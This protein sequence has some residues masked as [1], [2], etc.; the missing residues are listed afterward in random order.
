[1]ADFLLVH[2]SCHGA[3]CWRHVVPALQA[4]GHSVR[5]IDLPGHGEDRTPAADVTADLYRDAILAA[6]E[7]PVILVGH[8]MAGFPI[9]SVAEAAPEKVARLVFVCA[10]APIS[11]T[12]LL[13]MRKMAK[14]Q[15]ILD[16]IEKSADGVTWFPKEGRGRETFYHDCPEADVAF[17]LERIVPQAILPQATPIELGARYVSVPASYIRCSDDRTIDPDFQLEM[18]AGFAEADRYV[19]DCSHSPFFA[20]PTGLAG[21]LDKIA[22]AG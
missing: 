9:A 17:A 11:G 4:M 22:V 19:M 8:S 18:Q 15:L 12:S 6:I 5:A 3:W 20:D 21:L 7:T 2:G 10:Y 16:A 14:R 1:M 13:D